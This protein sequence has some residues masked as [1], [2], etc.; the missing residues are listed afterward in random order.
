MYLLLPLF[1]K[2][3][4]PFFGSYGEFSVAFNSTMDDSMIN[5]GIAMAG[6]SAMTLLGNTIYTIINIVMSTILLL[7]LFRGNEYMSKILNVSIIGQDNFQGRETINKFSN[8]NST[9]LSKV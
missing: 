7:T 2:Q 8:F 5:K 3:F 6:G 4:L 1:L 9:S